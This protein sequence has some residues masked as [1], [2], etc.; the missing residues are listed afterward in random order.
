MTLIVIGK[1]VSY[2]DLGVFA[3]LD[4][5]FHDFRVPAAL[6]AKILG[7]KGEN[8]M[9][10]FMLAFIPI[11]VAVDAVGLLPIFVSLTQD[12]DKPTKRKI[13]FQSILTAVCLAVAFIVAGREVF[14]FLGITVSDFMIAGG[15]ILFCIAILDLLTQNKERRLPAEEL[16]AVPIGTPLVVGPAVLTTCLISVDQHG[17]ALTIFAVL[18]NILFAGIVFSSSERLMAIFGKTGAQ[19]LSKILS[20]FLAAIAIMMI[21]RGILEIIALQ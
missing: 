2:C 5:N 16:G 10:E 12:L 8:F 3:N 4:K 20:L 9:K 13:I 21:R 14:K 11:F 18:I 15:A 17:A 6:F 1:N 19:A 7:S